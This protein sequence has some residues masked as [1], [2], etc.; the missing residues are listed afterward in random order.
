MSGYNKKDNR[1][2]PIRVNK[3][4][5]GL[6]KDELGGRVRTEFIALRP[7]LYTYKNLSGG[8][9]KK[10]KGV[11]KCILKRTLSFIYYK[12]CLFSSSENAYRKQLMFRNRLHEVHNVEVN[13]VALIRDDNKRIVQSNGV[14]TLAHGHKDSLFHST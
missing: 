14:S 7:K 6:M 5:I 10:C 11:K 4:V 9:D 3:K 8:G 2:L 12:H 1:P 13:K